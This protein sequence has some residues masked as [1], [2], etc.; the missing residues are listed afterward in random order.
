MWRIE[1]FLIISGSV[2][3]DV[4]SPQRQQSLKVMLKNDC[5]SCHGLTLKG[6]LGSS[7]LPETLANKNPDLLVSTILHGRKGTAMPAWGKLITPQEAHWLIK[8]LKK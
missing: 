1:L 3:A 4:P 7:L 5:G 8:Y 2:M 6:G